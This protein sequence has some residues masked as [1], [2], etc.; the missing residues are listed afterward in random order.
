[1]YACVHVRTVVE[2]I[3][4]SSTGEFETSIFSSPVLANMPRSRFMSI[5]Q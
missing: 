4:Y 3:I 2:N 1:M 5:K